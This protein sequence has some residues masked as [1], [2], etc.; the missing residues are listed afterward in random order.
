MATV[1]ANSNSALCIELTKIEEP[2]YLLSMPCPQCNG[3]G[4]QYS[5]ERNYTPHVIVDLLYNDLFKTYRVNGY[6]VN[7]AAYTE[8]LHRIFNVD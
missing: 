8:A 4:K 3:T 6:A 2:C 7:E 5:L 1:P